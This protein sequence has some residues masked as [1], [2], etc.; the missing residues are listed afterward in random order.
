VSIDLSARAGITEWT[1]L[2]VA[3][4]RLEEKTDKW[5]LYCADLNGRWHG[6][7]ELKPKK[8]IDELLDVI[9]RDQTRIFL[10]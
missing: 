4:M 7:I 9:D 3:Q 5:I 8:N 10:G 2:P 6:Y 1:S